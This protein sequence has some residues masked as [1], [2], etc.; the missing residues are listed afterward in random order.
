MAIKTKYPCYNLSLTNLPGEIWKDIPL[1]EDLY[2]ISSHGRVKSLPRVREIINTRSRT[3]IS[4]WTQERIRRI[5][6][7]KRWNSVINKPYFECTISLSFGNNRDKEALVHRLVYQAFVQDIN[8]EIDRLMVMHKDGN[9]LNNHYSN[10]LTGNRHDVL[11][12]AYR[13]K[14]HI[15]PF[16]LKTKREFREISQ[17]S[18]L[19]RQKKVVQYSSEGNRLCIFNS[20][21]EAA[22]QT[23]IRDSNI[24][25][26]LKGSALTAGGFIWHY[27]PGRKRINTDYIRR[28]RERKMMQ[29]RKPVQ[30]Y[31]LKGKPLKIFRSIAE[32][33]TKNNISPSSISNCLAGRLKQ[34]GG[35]I[36]KM[37]KKYKNGQ[38]P[39]HKVR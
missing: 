21:K 39:A 12:K 24:V 11:K 18:A 26:V 13:R 32:A 23:G 17:R 29:S 15:S 36:W 1:F 8:F 5:R 34:S 33:A 7:N 16:A 20:I 2:Q 19:T 28:G 9:G 22:Q 25:R 3:T 31:S 4:Y 35:Y 30:Q 14:R 10:L 6:V 38:R 37:A 27:Y